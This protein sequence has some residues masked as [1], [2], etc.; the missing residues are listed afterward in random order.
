M[1]CCMV[2]AQSS[3]FREQ[4]MTDGNSPGDSRHH[5]LMKLQCGRQEGHRCLTL[6][7]RSVAE[8]SR[9]LC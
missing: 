7:H 2:L 5:A 8:R 3:E 1:R 4:H 9:G 6:R